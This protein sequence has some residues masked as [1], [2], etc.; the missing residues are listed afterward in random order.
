M[1]TQQRRW[2]EVRAEDEVTGDQGQGSC[3]KSKSNSNPTRLEVNND[4]VP[5]LMLGIT[6]N[7]CS[8]VC[9]RMTYQ[10][11]PASLP[12]PTISLVAFHI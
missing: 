4:L 6:R 3:S 12:P 8:S 11:P 10:R 2:E 7:I 5:L 1:R 9:L